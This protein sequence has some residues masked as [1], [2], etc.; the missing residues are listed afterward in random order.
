MSQLTVRLCP[1][2]SSGCTLVAAATSSSR[3]VLTLVMPPYSGCSESMSWSKG[4]S[5]PPVMPSCWVG[6]PTVS[7]S[8]RSYL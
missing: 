6:L 4:C 3:S 7:L 1:K 8:V 2:T 5:A